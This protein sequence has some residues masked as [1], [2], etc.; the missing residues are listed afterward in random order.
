[1]PLAD[2][3]A[4]T[5]CLAFV[6]GSHASGKTVPHT[7]CSRETWF[8]ETD[9]AACAAALDLDCAERVELAP[10]AAG[11]AVFFGPTVLQTSVPN[12]SPKARWAVD[13]RFH[14][15]AGANAPPTGK[16]KRPEDWFFGVKDSF[17]LRAGP[18]RNVTADDA[19]LV[20]WA[21]VDRARNAELKL[22]TRKRGG[23]ASPKDLYDLDPVVTGPWMDSWTLTHRNRHVDRYLRAQP[24]K[25]RDAVFDADL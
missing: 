11:G 17:V 13:L 10:V 15:A 25:I 14:E 5:G 9:L 18:A 7:C 22:D 2:A 8:P 1:M 16:S 19:A 3:T 12:T 21:A 20:T 23:R 4:A 6:K 24:R